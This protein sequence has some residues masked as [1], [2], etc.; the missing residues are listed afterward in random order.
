MNYRNYSLLFGFSVWLIATL[1]FSLYGHIFLHV[2]NNLVI[3]GLFLFTV[4]VLYLLVRFVFNRF[5]LNNELK[6]RSAIYMAAPGMLGDV[7]CIKFH[8]IVF[9]NL[10]LEQV[11]VL[12]SW[13]LWVYTVVLFSGQINGKSEQLSSIT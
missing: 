4:P 6:I 13:V 3:S 11:V 7:F 9:P 8:S 2:E 1:I 5:N 12:G 10:S